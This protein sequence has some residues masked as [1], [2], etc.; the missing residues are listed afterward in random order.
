MSTLDGKR[1]EDQVDIM[2]GTVG[3]AWEVLAHSAHI[4]RFPYLTIRY[5]NLNADP[6]KF[7]FDQ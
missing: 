5:K 6:R 1:P 2:D 7:L 4:S 3:N